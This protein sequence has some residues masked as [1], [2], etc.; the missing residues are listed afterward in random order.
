[1]H[2]AVRWTYVV[3]RYVG[4]G[5]GLLMLMWCLSGM[6][7]MY[8]PYPSLP[9][10]A[11][12]AGLQPLDGGQCCVMPAGAAPSS[13]SVEMMHGRLLLTGGKKPV[14]LRTG[15]TVDGI[16]PEDARATARRFAPGAA[17][18][19]TIDHDQWTVAGEFRR[20]R[21]LYKLSLNDGTGTQLYVS[22]TSG[23]VVQS[24][25]A[26]Q[27]F[28][29]YLGAVPHWLYFTRLRADPPLWNQVVIWTSLVGSFLVAT[30]LYIGI[31]QWRIARR[32]GRWSSHRG[33]KLW[34]HVPG[35]VFG[36][37]LLSWVVSGL[38]SMNPWGLLEDDNAPDIGDLTGPPATFAQIGAALHAA[39]NA[40][41]NAGVVSLEAAPLHGK[42]YLI[43]T[44]RDGVRL[45]LDAT[46]RPVP[47]TP[48]DI[49]A[50]ARA[51]VH[52]PAARPTRLPTGDDYYFARDG[53]APGL[54][55]LRW[56]AANGDRFYVDP[57]SGEPVVAFG[58]ADRGYRWLFQGL[59]RLDF[60]AALRSRPAW[61]IVML[62]LL[63]GASLV[64]ATGVYL[65]LRYLGR[66]TARR[67]DS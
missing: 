44:R 19:E 7:M 22:G 46:E 45:R 5:L 52:D 36:V 61:D 56:V 30:G 35:L 33:A 1:M 4:I 48:T 6:V 26:A 43:A 29:N 9:Q 55:V 32:K 62:V 41:R 42:L 38:L 21:P 60:T 15:Q 17:T 2:I 64:S 58:A 28:W 57:V 8:M 31:R 34:H 65:A 63:A 40:E 20:D 49:A 50:I 37:F 67:V 23:K 59:H 25:T 27:R 18:L 54:P 10:A 39:L 12:I 11:R 47:L 13:F 53:A 14:D 66:L 3:H 51:V 16:T 24:V